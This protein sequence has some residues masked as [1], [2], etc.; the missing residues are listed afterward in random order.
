MDVRFAPLSFRE[1]RHQSFRSLHIS[2]AFFGLAVDFLPAKV[3]CFTERF[4]EKR[5]AFLLHWQLDRQNPN[6]GEPLK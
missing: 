6:I 3:W 1:F 2:G 5:R 4:G